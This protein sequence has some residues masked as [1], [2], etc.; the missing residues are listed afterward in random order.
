MIRTRGQ[1]RETEVEMRLKRPKEVDDTREVEET[2]G[3]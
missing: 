1:E 3:G 2:E